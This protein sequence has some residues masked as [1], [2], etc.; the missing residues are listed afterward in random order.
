MTVG[1]DYL[2]PLIKV[3]KEGLREWRYGGTC[4]EGKEERKEG[5]GS[6]GEWVLEEGGMKDDLFLPPRAARETY[7]RLKYIQHAFVHPHPDF[8]RPDIPIPPISIP[9]LLTPSKTTLSLVGSPKSPHNRRSFSP[10]LK[11]RSPKIAVAK[12]SRPSSAASSITDQS[13][14][15]GSEEDLRKPEITQSLEPNSSLYLMAENFKKLEREREKKAGRGASW[16]LGDKLKSARRS[17]KKISN[18]AFSKLGEGQESIRRRLKRVPKASSTVVREALSDTEDDKLN[19]Q[20]TPLLFSMSAST[21]NLSSVAQKE[22]NHRTPPPKPPR[23]FKTKDLR[24]FAT[25]CPDSGPGEDDEEVFNDQDFSV[26]VLSAVKK[27]NVVCSDDGGGG[28]GDGGSTEEG[29]ANGQIPSSKVMLRSESSPQLSRSNIMAAQNGDGTAAQNLAETSPKLQTITEDNVVDSSQVGGDPAH[30]DG[31]PAHING[32]PAHTDGAPSNSLSSPPALAGE[33]ETDAQVSVEVVV[34]G[35]T[36]HTVPLRRKPDP[37]TWDSSEQDPSTQEP[38]L[39]TSSSFVDDLSTPADPASEASFTAPLSLLDT[40]HASLQQDSALTDLDPDLS[41]RYSIMS[42]TSA[43]FYSAE[44][45]G[46]SKQ[47]SPSPSSDMMLCNNLLPLSGSNQSGPGNE[48]L[49]AISSLSMDDESFDTPPSSPMTSRSSSTASPDQA[50]GSSATLISNRNSYAEK[51]VTATPTATPTH[52]SSSTS[53]PGHTSAAST[54]KICHL[55]HNASYANAMR[56]SDASTSTLRAGTYLMDVGGNDL[57]E[58]LESDAG[59]LKRSDDDTVETAGVETG[60]TAGTAVAETDGHVMDLPGHT[61]AR[62]EVDGDVH[63]SVIEEPPKEASVGA[64]LQVPTKQPLQRAPS[65]PGPGQ[66]ETKEDTFSASLD[67]PL[68]T[69]TRSRSMTVCYEGSTLP[70]R[71]KANKNKGVLSNSR[72]DNFSTEY[73]EE[74]RRLSSSDGLVSYFSQKDLEDIFNIGPAKYTANEKIETL[75]EGEEEEEEGEGEREEEGE[76]EREEEGEGE[77]EA[78]GA[79]EDTVSMEDDGKGVKESPLNDVSAASSVFGSHA[80]SPDQA[81]QAIVLIPQ[82]ITPNRVKGHHHYLL[83]CIV[84]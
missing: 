34:D 40:S 72:D 45:S 55:T 6:R 78:A 82:D 80:V 50:K 70:L 26:D 66:A 7:I 81:E 27:M 41:K 2:F 5:G 28:G 49:R 47:N 1:E 12:I 39:D 64:E 59:T 74:G 84:M 37:S 16:S 83:Y 42:T 14:L 9:D 21:Q 3:R 44:S 36:V 15:N 38:S 62:I 57:V 24:D 20:S 54:P 18:Y 68:A 22:G 69:K 61:K 32:G 75:K 30:T 73:K 43:D 29:V 56:G 4:E 63:F 11:I 71:G 48:D 52:V 79:A 67:S 53:S 19:S 23:T 76:G 13:S 35:D 60:D 51:S 46:G 8:L 25:E 77:E 33:D 17:S 58:S 31:G 10:A 65:E